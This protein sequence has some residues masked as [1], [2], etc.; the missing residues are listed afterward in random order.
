MPR[1]AG[2]QRDGEHENGARSLATLGD[3]TTDHHG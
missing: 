3:V 1:R 2:R